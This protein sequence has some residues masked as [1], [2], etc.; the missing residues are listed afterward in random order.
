MSRFPFAG[1][2]PVVTHPV[3]Q[4]TWSFVSHAVPPDPTVICHGHVGEDGVFE[5]C[6]HGVGIGGFRS[7]RSNT[8]ESIF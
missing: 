4:M 8:E 2:C 1:W 3:D 6:L 7:A 5:D